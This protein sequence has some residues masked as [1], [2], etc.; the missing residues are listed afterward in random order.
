MIKEVLK[1]IGKVEGFGQYTAGLACLYKSAHITYMFIITLCSLNF[2]VVV[3][4]VICFVC[5]MR[6]CFQSDV[7]YVII[8]LIIIRRKFITCI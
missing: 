6:N 5:I 2:K 4:V 1:N 7:N 8:K 3:F